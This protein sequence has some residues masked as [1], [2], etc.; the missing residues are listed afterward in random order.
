MNITP[1][2]IDELISKFL[3]GE[4]SPDEAAQV[5]VW[6]SKSEANRKYL[7][8]FELIFIRA[9]S[10][11]EWQTFDVDAAW[12]KMKSKMAPADGRVIS[13]HKP[14][15][16][17]YFLRIAAGILI[18]ITAGIFGYKFL[19]DNS[20]LKPVEVI[21]D[22]QTINDTLP[23]GSNVFLNKETKLDY[24]YDKKAKV[25]KVKLRGEAYFH[26]KHE[27]EKK[28]IVE[29]EG[30]FIRDI[31]TSFN[32]TAYPE[33][34]TVEVVVETGEVQFFTSENPGI[35][36]KAGGKGVYNKKDKTFVIDTPENNVL[37]YK[38][39]FFSFSNADLGSVVDALNE[40]Y[41]KKIVIADHLKDCTLTVSFNNEDVS[42]I[43]LIISE[44]LGLEM[45]EGDKKI[46]L[47]G[48][49]CE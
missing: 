12:G 23:D 20:G 16:T 26:I 42:E 2:H 7:E 3:A 31:G 30:I 39:K 17:F 36:L 25:H 13:L 33:S 35:Y 24:A 47:E 46:L 18:L 9:A 27:D 6:A 37:A 1:D 44:T 15:K 11:K 45:K 34:N 22:H 40:V 43:A 8:Q 38:T 19:F 5:K 41:D 29:A 48:E 32:V 21:A 49:G 10:I 4:A 14:K 28:F